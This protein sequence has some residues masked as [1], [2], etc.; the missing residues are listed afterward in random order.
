[1]CNL[2]HLCGRCR[3]SF[4]FNYS[5]CNQRCNYILWYALIIQFTFVG[6]VLKVCG[7]SN[8]DQS[9]FC[10]CLRSNDKTQYFLFHWQLIAFLFFCCSPSSI[11]PLLTILYAHMHRFCFAMKCN[12]WRWHPLKRGPKI[13]ICVILLRSTTTNPKLQK[14]SVKSKCPSLKTYI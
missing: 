12:V 1:M 10:S 2:Y 4:L 5:H 13:T 11:F 14:Y 8:K 3:F 7:S 9:S 6:N